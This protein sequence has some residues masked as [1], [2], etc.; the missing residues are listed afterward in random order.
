MSGLEARVTVLERSSAGQGTHT[1][2]GSAGNASASLGTLFNV[3]PLGSPSVP[4]AVTAGSSSSAHAQVATH[5]VTTGP[6]QS[7]LATRL[8]NLEATVIQLRTELDELK[9]KEALRGGGLVRFES[10]GFQ[11]EHDAAAFVTNHIQDG[12]L[13]VGFLFDIYLLCNLVFRM[14]SGDQDFLK[15][16]ETINKLDLK[17]NRAAQA[18]LAFKSPVPDL[19]VDGTKTP[20]IWTVTK[21][22]SHFNR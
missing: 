5:S 4:Q 11:N 3:A 1:S 22:G 18:M 12:S 2:P 7:Q 8:A 21:D 17:T 15:L 13:Q 14:A 6:S 19:F 10:L 9:K 20:E 16:T